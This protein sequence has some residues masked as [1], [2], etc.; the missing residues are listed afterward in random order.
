MKLKGTNGMA[1][2]LALFHHGASLALVAAYENGLAAV[3]FLAEDGV[4]TTRYQSQPHSQPILSLDLSP[5][6]DY[7]L[8]SSADAIVAKHPIPPSGLPVKVGELPP[9][10]AADDTRNDRHLDKPPSLL[11]QA[12]RGATSP[13]VE[14]ASRA[15][16]E[17][18]TQPLKVINTKHA[19]QQSLKI[20]SDGKVF[21]TAG[22]DSRVRVYSAKTMKEIAVLKW[23]SVGCY[24]VAFS[25]I[26]SET[27]S[28][29][30]S[31]APPSHI[32]AEEREISPESAERSIVPRMLEMTV[33]ERRVKYTETAHWLVA[34]SKDGRVSLWDIF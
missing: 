2:A 32:S 12:L 13:V 18:V 30:G 33:K 19:G 15:G 3:A 10:P 31:S 16:Q 23:H 9:A 11:S 7:F 8:T 4:W 14:V 22:W 26:H 17:L 21:A 34:G 29:A 6:K 5:G 20:R 28:A 24:A 27:S 1:M 25:N